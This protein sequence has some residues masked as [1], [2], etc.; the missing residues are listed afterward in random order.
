[1]KPLLDGQWDEVLSGRSRPNGSY[2]AAKFTFFDNY[3]PPAFKI[4]RKKHTRHY[5][6][7]FAGPGVWNDPSG[8]RHL[9]SPLRV[10][11]LSNQLEYGEGFTEAYLVN[12]D[13]EDHAALSNRVDL[14]VE[15]R[16]TNLPRHRIH[17]VQGDANEANPGILQKIHE[18]SWIFVYSDIEKPNHWPFTSVE[19]LR[20]QGHSSIDFYM[21]FPLQMAINRILGYSASHPEAITRFYG[22]DSWR[23]IVTDRPTSSQSKEFLR[24]M[25]ACYAARLRS[26]DWTHVR[27]QRKVNDVGERTLYY[28]FFATNHPVAGAL[29]DWEGVSDGDE[30]FR[31]Q[32]ELF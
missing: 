25:E 2:A 1:M 18:K 29:S 3:L 15:R 7:L 32:G 11:S 19:A 31:G 22:S 10:L 16:L 14:M 30:R 8:A 23:E 28:M 26:V 4:T 9:G 21:L 17:T 20:A 27:R 6:D 13:P 5:I 24:Q 12:K